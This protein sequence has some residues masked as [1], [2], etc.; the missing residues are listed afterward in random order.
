[1]SGVRQDLRQQR[2]PEEAHEDPR[3]RQAVRLHRLRQDVQAAEHVQAASAHAL[4]RQGVRVRRVRQ[5][6]HPEA[7]SDH[8]SEEALRTSDAAAHDVHKLHH[9]GLAEGGGEEGNVT[10]VR[11]AFRRVRRGLIFRFRRVRKR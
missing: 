11:R 7:G 4:G 2:L 3:R 10:R 8:A 5:E 1:M 9:Q 6:L